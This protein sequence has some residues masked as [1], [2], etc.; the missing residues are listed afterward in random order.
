ML[1]Y[2]GVK[3]LTVIE[4][5]SLDFGSGLNVITGETGAGKSVLAG[6]LKFL[7]GE[8]FNRAVLRDPEKKLFVEGIFS[9]IKGFD[10]DTVEQYEI[11]D[12]LILSRETDDSGKNK[13]IINGRVAPV[14]KLRDIGQS[15]IDIH[16]QNENQFLFNPSK[17]IDFLD[18]FVSENLK[19]KYSTS[20]SLYKSKVSELAD[21]KKQIAE[22]VRLKE[23]YEFQLEEINSLNIDLENDSRIDERI[24]FLSHIEKIRESAVFCVNVLK[25]GE[26]S[27]FDLIGKAEKSIS[28]ILNLSTEL[29]KAYESLGAA[30]SYIND[31][32]SYIENVLEEQDSSPDELNNLIDRKYKLQNLLKKYGSD[33]SEVLTYKNSL[34]EKLANVS[35]GDKRI[36]AVSQEVENLEKDALKAADELNSSRRSVAESLS[37]K[38]C[39]ILKELELPASRFYVKFS[40]TGVLDNVG[41]ITAEFYISTNAGFEPG[42]LSTVA[43]GG[44]VSRVMLALKEVFAEADS[45]G[46]MLFDEIDSGISGKAAKSVAERL[47]K[48]SK[49]KQIIVI[50]H[51][52]V[53]A[54]Q[55]E[56]HFHI[57]KSDSSGKSKTDISK[58]DINARENIIAT[59]IAGEATEYSLVQARE[60]LKGAGNLA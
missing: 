8:R 11:D 59:M 52:P 41:G 28:S 9:D 6:A 29:G 45:I 38:V 30:S 37:V 4:S 43:S 49:K 15:L 3:N 24:K 7:A 44:E 53:V 36:N 35:L 56:T 26:I 48:L 46:T 23:M 14:A 55:G 27:A 10:E 31:A 54:A 51:L 39:E 13:A 21:L 60:L 42:P 5:V 40:E 32:L 20:Y 34:E 2:L 1:T 18:F 25:E 17:H 22:T 33:L 16:G 47:K 58:L 57:S 50:T 19:E 12:E